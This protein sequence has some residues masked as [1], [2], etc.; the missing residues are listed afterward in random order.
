MSRYS[1]RWPWIWF[2]LAMIVLAGGVV[3]ALLLWQTRSSSTQEFLDPGAVRDVAQGVLQN[4]TSI[5]EEWMASDLPDDITS[6]AIKEQQSLA[7]LSGEIGRTEDLM[8]QVQEPPTGQEEAPPQDLVE[9]LASLSRAQALLE[10][11]LVQV[12]ALLDS[13]QPLEGADAAYRR[14]REMLMAAVDSHNQAVAAGSTAFATA[15]QEASSAATSLQESEA[16]LAA[17]QIEGLD[18]ATAAA[19]AAALENTTQR[20]M[21]ACQKGESNDAAGHNDLMAEVQSELS[22]SASSILSSID[23]TSWLRPVLEDLM[24]P[25]CDALEDARALLSGE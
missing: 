10:R 13:L 11:D 19:A 7:L 8:E 18:L 16:A 24:R 21:E 4:T 23:I 25:A 22:A 20:F 3:A 14:G 17:A 2:G 9:A 1:R 6:L 15:R 5:A 12:G